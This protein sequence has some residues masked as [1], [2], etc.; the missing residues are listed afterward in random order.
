MT[1]LLAAPDGLVQID[2]DSVEDHSNVFYIRHTNMTASDE[3][4]KEMSED[5]KIVIHHE[6]IASI[7]RDDYKDADS[8][9][10]QNDIRDLKNATEQGALVGVTYSAIGHK[11]TRVG[12]IE[13]GTDV[14]FVRRKY[15]GSERIYKVAE[16]TD[17]VDVHLTECPVI[18]V[19]R[20]LRGATISEYPE[21]SQRAI[22]A[23]VEGTS[24]P[25]EVWSLSSGQFELLARRDMEARHEGLELR[26]PS[27]RTLKDV[28]VLAV[29]EN[30]EDI[31]AQ[32]SFTKSPTEAKNKRDDLLQY[33]ADRRYLYVRE[34]FADVSD[35]HDV[36]LRS[37]EAVFNELDQDAEAASHIS[38]MLDLSRV[39]SWY[40]G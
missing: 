20:S 28:D 19:A 7:E 31:I 3:F 40:S 16:I 29:D 24:V 5:G 36:N 6:D 26:L 30:G 10:A 27:G 32:V 8:R 38:K 39:G 9:F 14:E 21:P 18:F 2:R 22:K 15:N 34:R 4:I 33:D 1:E 37:P 25:R 13:P 35:G 17:Y 23:I 12:V 11:Y